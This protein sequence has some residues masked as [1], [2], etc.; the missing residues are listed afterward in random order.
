MQ[1]RVDDLEELSG[2]KRL[3]EC[4]HGA[5]SFCFVENL[6]AAMRGDEK[7]RDLGLEIAQV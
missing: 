2:M 3:G 7:N 4:A 5:A 6:R 1:M